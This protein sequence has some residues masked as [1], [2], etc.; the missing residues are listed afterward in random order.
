M[1]PASSAAAGQTFL[2]TGHP[3]SYTVPA[4][5]HYLHIAAGGGQGGS[6]HAGGKGGLGVQVDARYVAVK[7]GDTLR[8]VVGGNG[9]SAAGGGKLPNPGEGGYNGGGDG[10]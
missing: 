1:V 7:P 9:G 6:G 10:A 8:V 4:G 2:F 5:V 3:E